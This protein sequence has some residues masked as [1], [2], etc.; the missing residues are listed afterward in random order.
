MA[1]LNL[2][3]YQPKFGQDPAVFNDMY[4]NYINNLQS[5]NVSDA[6]SAQNSVQS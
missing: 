3:G 4:M 2:G 6:G 1:K 5:D